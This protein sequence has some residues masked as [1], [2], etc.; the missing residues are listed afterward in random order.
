[1][2]HAESSLEKGNAACEKHRAL[3]RDS[4]PACHAARETSRAQVTVPPRFRRRLRAR[5]GAAARSWRSRRSPR[6]RAEN[7]SCLGNSSRAKLGFPHR[8]EGL[9]RRRE[10]FG[11]FADLE[12]F[13]QAVCGAAIF[14]LAPDTVRGSVPYKA[15]LATCVRGGICDDAHKMQ[16]YEGCGC[17]GDVCERWPCIPPFCSKGKYGRPGN[18][19]SRAQ[20]IRTRYSSK[21]GKNRRQ[22]TRVVSRT[23]CH[24]ATG[25][26][27]KWG[28][29]EYLMC[30]LNI[31]TC[32]MGW[33]PGEA[34]PNTGPY[35]P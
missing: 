29:Q 9:R 12:R 18:C 21:F 8:I 11:N 22:H 10:N 17:L 31:G 34:R 19:A 4:R 1:M 30:D 25:T 16:C 27:E 24:T 35:A 28:G 13:P 15:A 32:L 14:A 5:A 26:T 23:G 7:A 2:K 20:S 33:Y 3:L 6:G